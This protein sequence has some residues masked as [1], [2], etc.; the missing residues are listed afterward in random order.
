MKLF[1]CVLLSMVC[2]F[3][4]AEDYGSAMLGVFH[5]AEKHPSE[6]KFMNIGHRD[7]FQGLV[8]QYEIGGWVDSAGN[9]RKSSPYAAYQIGLQAVNQVVGRFM[10]GPAIVG[11]TDNR[12]GAVFPQFTT[13]L[14][15]GIEGEHGV[16]IGFKYKHISSAGLS[17]PN[18]GRDFMGIELSAG[19]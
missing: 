2:V 1:L 16:N 4:Y 15:F 14:Y 12:L 5:G 11:I 6:I 7:S 18:V 9:G 10:M 17:S 8:A 13:D 19:L 3:A